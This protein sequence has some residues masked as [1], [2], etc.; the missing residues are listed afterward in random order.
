MKISQLIQILQRS[1]NINGDQEVCLDSNGWRH[2]E[3]VLLP[4]EDGIMV[5]TLMSGR[6]FS[7][8]DDV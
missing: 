4:N 6:E 8:T 7:W 2:I 3:A 5:P 1:A